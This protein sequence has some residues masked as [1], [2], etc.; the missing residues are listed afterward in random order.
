MILIALTVSA[1]FA[2]AYKKV[3]IRISP[4]SRTIHVFVALPEWITA[5]LMIEALYFIKSDQQMTVSNR[6][7][8]LLLVAVL[9]YAISN[10]LN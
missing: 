1:D 10:T 8:V 3:D 4:Y 5:Y 6:Q 7:I 9:A 2:I